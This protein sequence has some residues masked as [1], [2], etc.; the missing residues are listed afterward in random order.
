MA[1]Q[2]TTQITTIITEPSVWS[3][4]SPTG[5]GPTRPMTPP[6]ANELNTLLPRR[7]P[8]RS[9]VSRW[10]AAATAVTSSGA[11]VPTATIV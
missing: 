3:V 7:L 2:L 10:R 1:T 6:T 11:D 9:S 4:R 5:P 8:T